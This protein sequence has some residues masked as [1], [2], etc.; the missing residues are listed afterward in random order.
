M[1]FW[2]LTPVDESYSGWRQ[3][4]YCGPAVFRA[5]SE[6]DARELATHYFWTMSHFQGKRDSDPW[7]SASHVSAEKLSGVGLPE[8]SEAVMLDPDPARF[9]PPE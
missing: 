5:P 6:K 1:E 8:G 3:S 9:A 7:M 2:K 4:K